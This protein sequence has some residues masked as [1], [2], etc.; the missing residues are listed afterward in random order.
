MGQ[1]PVKDSLLP[2]LNM[3]K[4]K[5]LS[6]RDGR[7]ITWSDVQEALVKVAENNEEE[8]LA[9]IVDAKQIKRPRRAEAINKDIR[10]G[11]MVTSQDLGEQETY[12]G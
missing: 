7:S 12:T 2:S 8:F 1:I 11:N 3:L 6:K 9:E 10:Q 4:L 5:A